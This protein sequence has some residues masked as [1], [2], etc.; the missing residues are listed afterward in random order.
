VKGC[1]SISFVKQPNRSNRTGYKTGYQVAHR[2]VVTQ[3]VKSQKSL[4]DLEKFFNVGHITINK[5]H[6]NHKEY[7]AQYVVNRRTDLLETIIPFFE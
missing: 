3:G 1:F 7:L 4:E 2:F 5:R 6:D